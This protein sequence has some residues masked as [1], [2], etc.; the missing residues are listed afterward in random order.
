MIAAQDRAND[1]EPEPLETI[2]NQLVVTG[3]IRLF[4]L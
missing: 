2:E 3:M 4:R 1:D